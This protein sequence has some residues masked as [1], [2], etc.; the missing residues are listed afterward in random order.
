MLKEQ[1]MIGRNQ[2]A[3]PS[4]QKPTHPIRDLGDYILRIYKRNVIALHVVDFARSLADIVCL[5]SIR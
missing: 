4:L 5:K 1:I 3:S 2:H